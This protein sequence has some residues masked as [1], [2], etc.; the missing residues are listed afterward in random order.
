MALGS[1]LRSLV[2]HPLSWIGSR[3]AHEWRWAVGGTLFEY[4]YYRRLAPVVAVLVA[5][6]IIWSLFVLALGLL[7]CGGSLFR[8][9]AFVQNVFASLLVLP[10]SLA[11]GVFAGTLLQKHAL[12]FQVRHAADRLGDS[13]RLATFE[14]IV[15]LQRE[16]VLPIDLAGP[17]SHQ[18]VRRARLVAYHSFANS[19]GGLRLPLGFEKRVYTTVDA[20]VSCFSRSPDLRIAFPRSFDLIEH[21]QSL[22]A[23]IRAGRSHSAP[24]D[25]ALVVLHFAEHMINDLD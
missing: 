5:F 19:E 7:F 1:R 15:F 4:R 16:C 11:V 25:T 2:R 8:Q 12:R 23:E 3:W 13:V 14:F 17:V 24:T 6:A 18:F 10:L 22:I 21:L 9:R 20:L